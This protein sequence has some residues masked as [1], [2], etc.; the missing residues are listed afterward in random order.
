MEDFLNRYMSGKK[1]VSVFS[2]CF[3]I[4][5]YLTADPAVNQQ[6]GNGWKA[7][8]A[9]AVITPA[10]PVWMA[11]YASREHP[12]EGTLV[13]LWAKA[14]AIEDAKGKKVV[15]ITTDLLGIP[16]KMS[17]RIRDQI[18]IRHGLTRSQ[19]ILSSSHTHT[20]PVLT[21][22][23][24]DIYPLDDKQLQAIKKYSDELE[25]KIISLTGEAIKSMVPAQISSQN[26]VTRFQVNRRNNKEATLAQ[27][28]ELK[29]PN[30]YSVP[31]LKIEDLSGNLMAVAFGYA[32][33]ATVLSF[34]QFS[35]DYP[36]F[37]Q[38]ELEKLYPGVTA[39][40]FQGAGADQNPLPRRTVA[41]AQQY[42]KELAA[43]V[44]RVLNE[45]MNKLEPIISTAYSEISLLFADP[46]SKE[47]LQ[48]I[49]SETEGYQKS[50]A[51]NQLA[52][53]Q[54]KGS[55]IKSYPYPIQIWKLGNQ[56]IMAM[57]GEVVI[58]YSIQL[59]K[60]FGPEI[61]V[62][63]YVNDDMAYIPSE[64]ILSEGGYEGES[65]QMVYGLPSK[66]AP[67]IQERIMNEF[68]KLA[69][70]AGIKQIVP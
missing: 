29:G 59:K 49:E 31:V 3:F 58:E 8:I 52:T 37:A 46:P 63:G 25:K 68:K 55:L 45:D 43:A 32:C 24:F 42:G 61:F 10:E 9:R 51:S 17:S 27:Q 67:G 65:S 34:Y 26:G 41:L 13:D 35:G 36:G 66:W 23:L 33:H 62:M 70:A 50:W 12:S 28:T 47:A 15:L 44:E 39:M 64:T 38:I 57:G 6:S 69:T 19:I 7:G 30:D 1:I 5:I 21:D 22:A 53:L 56:G 4:V 54:K 20:G 60:L 18:A 48:K 11:G 2:F 16:A 14:L 40:F